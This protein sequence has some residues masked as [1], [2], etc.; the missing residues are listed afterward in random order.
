MRLERKKFLLIEELS[1]I[2][3]E[4]IDRNIIFTI[5]NLSLPQ[6]GGVMNVILSIF[7]DDKAEKVIKEL[8]EESSKI[9]RA[10]R[11]KTNLRYL[12]K[13]I[14]FKLSKELKEFQIIDKILK[15]LKY[16]N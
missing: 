8:N 2:I 16:N 4:I 10:L 9:K 6:K 12:P 15:N 3:K 1:K 13:K 5:L 11:R 14:V 7:P